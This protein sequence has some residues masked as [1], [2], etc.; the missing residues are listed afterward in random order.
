MLRPKKVQ[1]TFNAN[2]DIIRNTH[3]METFKDITAYGTYVRSIDN[4]MM[5]IMWWFISVIQAI[6]GYWYTLYI[7][8]CFLM[9]E[10]I[11]W[12]CF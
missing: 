3:K 9:V 11:I 4:K 10:Y 8:I 1:N 12:D 7:N 6:I 2:N 5:I